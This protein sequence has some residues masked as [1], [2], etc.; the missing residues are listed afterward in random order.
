M[1]KQKKGE[2]VVLCGDCTYA[3]SDASDAHM[4]CRRYPPGVVVMG[5]SESQFPR[6]KK[7]SWCGEGS[8]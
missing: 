6:V 1:S 4:R 5:A 7:T 8:L 3:V 2:K